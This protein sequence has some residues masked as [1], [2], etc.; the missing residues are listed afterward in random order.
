M[1]SATVGFDALVLMA[2]SFLSV[3]TGEDGVIETADR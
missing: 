2:A 1:I 3:L